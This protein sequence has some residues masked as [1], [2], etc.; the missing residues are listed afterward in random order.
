MDRGPGNRRTR[1]APRKSRANARRPPP[2]IHAWLIRTT[3]VH[4][5]LCYIVRAFG[6]GHTT[7]VGETVEARASRFDRTLLYDCWTHSINELEQLRQ[8]LGVEMEP[9][10]T[11]H[12]PGTP[13][14][15]NELERR[16][17]RLQNLFRDGDAPLGR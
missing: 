13:E 3:R 5:H 17:A 9:V 6:Q 11:S 12:P 8:E 2:K 10:A 15:V 7:D 16:A 4:A 1:L 14:K